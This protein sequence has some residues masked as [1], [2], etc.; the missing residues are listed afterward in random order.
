MSSNSFPFIVQLLFVVVVAFAVTAVVA[1]AV[2]AS[3]STSAYFILFRFVCLCSLH[4]YEKLS[5]PVA[6]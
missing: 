1:A 3:A 4:S 2:C 6:F 5:L